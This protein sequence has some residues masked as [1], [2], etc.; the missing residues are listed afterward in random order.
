MAEEAVIEVTAAV[1]EGPEAANPR[2]SGPT[3]VPGSTY[4]LRPPLANR[5]PEPPFTPRRSEK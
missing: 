2:P 1:D 3:P 4:G 5:A